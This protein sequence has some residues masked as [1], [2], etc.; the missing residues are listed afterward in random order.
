[1]SKIT[2]TELVNAYPLPPL[3]AKD[4]ETCEDLYFRA[5]NAEDRLF[6]YLADELNAAAGFKEPFLAEL[7]AAITDLELVYAHLSGHRSRK[8]VEKKTQ[9]QSEKTVKELFDRL[10]TVSPC[11][12]VPAQCHQLESL[13]SPPGWK[14]QVRPDGFTATPEGVTEGEVL[15]QDPGVTREGTEPSKPAGGKADRAAQ[16][17]SNLRKRAEKD[18]PLA[19]FLSHLD[20]ACGVSRHKLETSGLL[21]ETDLRKINTILQHEAL[22][23]NLHRSDIVRSSPAKS[24]TWYQFHPDL[25]LV[26]AAQRHN[27]TEGLMPFSVFAEGYH[28]DISDKAEA[29]LVKALWVDET[30]YKILCLLGEMKSDTGFIDGA[31]IG[32][33]TRQS[34]LGVGRS[35]ASLRRLSLEAG[36]GPEEFV[37]TVREGDSRFYKLRPAVLAVLDN[38]K[39]KVELKDAS[40]CLA[41]PAKKVAV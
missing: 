2:P 9:A 36:L 14:I 24:G 27:E 15:P 30:R 19:V 38:I 5:F 11:R 6:L 7:D 18:A 3:E 10:T 22:R 25:K 13:P 1:V 4:E 21:N 34:A 17:L 29:I 39:A 33:R 37:E 8:P 20:G 23:L 26:L 16:V 40:S 41:S 32:L 28:K 12:D 31:A 35:V